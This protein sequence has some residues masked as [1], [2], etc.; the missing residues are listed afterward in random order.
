LDSLC[1]VDGFCGAGGASL[2][3]EM[4]LGQSPTIGVNHDEDAIAVHAINHPSTIHFEQDIYTVDPHKA[5]GGRQP[6]GAWWSPDCTHHSR[7][8]GGKPLSNKRRG[9][10]RAV[11]SWAAR[12]RPRLNLV[13][14]VVDMLSWGPLD[15]NGRPRTKEA[16]RYFRHWIGTFRKLG[17]RVEWRKLRACDYG[18]P[19]T[20]ERLYVIARLDGDPVW[21]SPTH[22]EPGNVLGLPSYLDAASCIDWSIPCRSIFDREKPLVPKTESRIARGIDKFV[23]NDPSPYIV[24]GNVPFLIQK[25]FGERVGQDPRTFD[26]RRPLS[27]VVAGGVKHELV[28]AFLARHFGGRGTPGSHLDEPMRTVTTQ[29][30]HGLVEAVLDGEPDRSEQVAAFLMAYYGTGT[31]QSLRRP[32][33]TVTTRDRFALVTVHGV[34]HRITD[35]RTRHLVPRELAR[36]QGFPDSYVFDRGAGGKRLSTSAQVRLIGN[37]VCPPVAAALVRA[38]CAEH[39]IA[40]PAAA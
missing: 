30:H 23:L 38:N 3:I 17:Y 11:T 25:G 13:E 24:G 10:P 18:A 15:D 29:D 31:G 7:A 39:A 14:N 36:A 26:I 19:T 20:R 28:V 27:T 32:L 9:L 2:G 37:S 33:R 16:G 21:P 22:G 1:I 35:I 5:T 8:K 40:H 12:V 6:Y 34:P 4:A